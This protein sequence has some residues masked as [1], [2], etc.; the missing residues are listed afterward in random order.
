MIGLNLFLIATEV[1]KLVDFN[2]IYLKAFQ[3]GSG[4]QLAPSNK[5]RNYLALLRRFTSIIIVVMVIA[6]FILDILELAQC[7]YSLP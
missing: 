2:P 4:A 7:F 3:A 6:I 5:Q 1:E